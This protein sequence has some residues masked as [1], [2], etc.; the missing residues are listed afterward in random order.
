MIEINYVTNLDVNEYSG[1]W[2]GMNHQV[3]E[4]LRKRVK[5]HLV[6]K[7]NPPVLKRE[8]YISKFFRTVSLEGSFSSFSKRRLDK[9]AALVESRWNREADITF[10][11]GATPWLHVRNKKPYAM[12]LDASF[13][14]YI[15]VYHDQGQ[16]N[17]AQLEYLFNKESQ[18]LERAI[19]VFFSSR[20]ALEDAKRS[21]GIS[22]ENFCVAGV[23][24]GLEGAGDNIENNAEKYFLFVGLDFLGKGGKLV[25]RAFDEVSKKN[26]GIKLK[27]VGQAP[28]KEYLT[29]PG[30]EYLGLINKSTKEGMCRLNSLYSGAR[31][32]LLPTKKDM[33]PLVIIEAA[34]LG[35]P[36]ITVDNF[37]IPE[38]VQHRTTGILMLSS[39]DLT[40]QLQNAMTELCENDILYQKMK[41]EA[42]IFTRENFTWDHVGERIAQQLTSAGIILN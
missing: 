24:G 3:Y 13:A 4:Q 2:S 12:Y 22:G 10:F 42:P 37:G 1:G 23:G 26:Q 27:I 41:Q 21:Y 33:T 16:F 8:K 5:I 39:E 18:F 35:C 34:S 11:H 36:V 25:V 32:L 40:R 9:I 19:K 14:T 6:D 31:A 30:I 28:P 17:A 38:I 20:W 29:H 15:R 7:I